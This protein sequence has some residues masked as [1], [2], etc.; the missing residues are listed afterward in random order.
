[1]AT[2]RPKYII[3]DSRQAD[4][5]GG[6]RSLRQS[7]KGAEDAAISRFRRFEMA[8][9]SILGPPVLRLS[10]PINLLARVAVC[11]SMPH[12]RH[13]ARIEVCYEVTAGTGLPPANAL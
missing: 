4:W 7:N 2:F 6:M 9:A 13:T 8:G 10:S 5:R 1:M 3:L 11:S 12:G